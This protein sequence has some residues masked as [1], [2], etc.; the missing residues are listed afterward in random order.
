LGRR[1]RRNRVGANDRSRAI[2]AASADP[3]FKCLASWCRD[4]KLDRALG[5]LL[6]HYC[7][8]GHTV[9]VARVPDTQL[10][11]PGRKGQCSVRC[12][13]SHPRKQTLAST[14]P[15]PPQSGEG[16]TA[17]RRDRVSRKEPRWYSAQSLAPAR[18]QP[19][20]YGELFHRRYGAARC[21]GP[22]L[23]SARCRARIGR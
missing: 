4:L 19:E 22:A 12:G 10:A 11:G 2:S 9:A 14:P 21:E 20:Q 18:R 13:H 6:K 5:L 16:P 7:P 3:R 17:A 23:S 8:R 15:L 1:E